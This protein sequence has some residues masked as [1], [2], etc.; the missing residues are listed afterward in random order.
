MGCMINSYCRICGLYLSAPDSYAAGRGSCPRCKQVLRIP[1]PLPAD[2]PGFVEGLRYIAEPASMIAPSGAA[3]VVVTAQLGKSLKYCCAKCRSVYES[4]QAPSRPQGQCPSCGTLNDESAGEVV[5]FPRGGDAGPGAAGQGRAAVPGQALWDMQGEFLV[6]KPAQNQSPSDSIIEPIPLDPAEPVPVSVPPPPPTKTPA[7]PGQ[8]RLVPTGQAQTSSA[9]WF[10]LIH[11]RAIGP[12]T[13]EAMKT[14][15]RT[16]KVSQAV[17]AW[18]RGMEIWM[19][20]EEI[21]QLRVDLAPQTKASLSR[22]PSSPGA[23]AGRVAQN[24]SNMVWMSISAMCLVVLLLVMRESLTDFGPAVPRVAAMALGFAMLLCLGGGI[25][26][27]VRNWRLFNQSSAT[28]R[29]KW[30]AGATGLLICILLTGLIGLHSRQADVVPGSNDSI[31][32]ARRI[33]DTLLFE[34]ISESYYVVDWDKLIVN[35]E[36][37]GQKHAGAASMDDK[38]LL[39]EGVYETFIDAFDPP[40]DRAHTQA[41]A[42]KNWRVV[43]QRMDSTVVSA[44]RPRSGAKMLF[45]LQGD[46][47]IALRIIKSGNR[48]VGR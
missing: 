29:A 3:P 40:F 46:R 48:E 14:L 33:V 27:L 37:F 26:R 9:G 47:L 4:L 2:S 35:G 22:V 39:I 13:T 8:P 16:G 32:L 1:V 24:A 34:D 5:E 17:F 6:A 15:L 44:T 23:R 42:M 25:V 45:T 10:Y 20:I 31:E 12:I 18:R 41:S 19:P 38:Q 30:F 7:K 11:G 36:N 43:Q 28:L 21:P